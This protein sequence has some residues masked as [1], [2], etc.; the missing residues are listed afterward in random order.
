MNEI[1]TNIT[2]LYSDYSNLLQELKDTVIKM[3][4]NITLKLKESVESVNNDIDSIKSEF[5]ELFASSIQPLITSITEIEGKFR[6]NQKNLE[7]QYNLI[8]KSNETVYGVIERYADL[9]SKPREAFLLIGE[10][11]SLPA[12]I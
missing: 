12:Y 10:R 9:I 2:S 11:I 7:K 4:K 5:A 1:T 8:E 3:Q 6:E